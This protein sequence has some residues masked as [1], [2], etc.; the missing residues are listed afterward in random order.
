MLIFRGVSRM[1]GTW[2]FGIPSWELT[3]LLPAGTFESMIFLL[4]RWGYVTVVPWRLVSMS[5]FQMFSRFCK[6]TLI[7]GSWAIWS[8]DDIWCVITC[9]SHCWCLARVW[10]APKYKAL[11]FEDDFQAC[12]L[13]EYLCVCIYIYIHIP[14]PS[15]GCQLDPKGWWIDTL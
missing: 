3:Y 10:M 7:S 5:C 13:V 4:L 1:T 9:P 12:F 8:N 6:G 15:K 11:D 14:A 2:P